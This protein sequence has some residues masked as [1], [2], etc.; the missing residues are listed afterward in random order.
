MQNDLNILVKGYEPRKL[1]IKKAQ[2]RDKPELEA[3]AKQ[4]QVYKNQY[5]KVLRVTAINVVK[6]LDNL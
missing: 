3:L 1:R 5:R 6:F 4:E 2:Y